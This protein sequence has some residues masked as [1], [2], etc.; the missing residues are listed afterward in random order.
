MSDSLRIC[1][2]SD[3][4]PGLHNSWG[5]AE[6]A[7][8]RVVQALAQRG[9]DISAITTRPD[10]KNVTINGISDLFFVST[11]ETATGIGAFRSLKQLTFPFD[12]VSYIEVRKVLRKTRPDVVHLHRINMISLSAALCAR[13]MGI[14]VVAS[15]YD[16]YY[17]CPRE[18]AVDGDGAACTTYHSRVCVECMDIRGPGF[19]KR[20]FLAARRACF[21]NLLKG[22]NFHVLSQSS[23]NILKTYGI[24]EGRIEKILQ[25]FPMTRDDEPSRTRKG[26]ITYI[27]WIQE[28]KGFHILLEAMPEIIRTCPEAR[29]TA[30]GAYNNDAYFDRVRNLIDQKG[31]AGRVEMLGKRDHA[32]VT[33]YVKESNVVVIPEQWDNMSP[34]VLVEAMSHGKPVVAS[35]IGGIPEFVEDG[36]SGLLAEPS[37]SEDFA[38]KISKVLA[39]EAFS[40]EISRS[41]KNHIRKI[42]DEKVI[43]K[44]YMNMYRKI[45]HA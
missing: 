25:V 26:L 4:L 1:H 23:L 20:S 39:D 40:E 41:A 14:P 11:V 31:L 36:K 8:L 37:S 18:T 17:F 3:T 38:G 33:R 10:L 24:D 12:P 28:R 29:L 45:A 34:V 13:K 43:I 9:V 42:L 35:N 21:D 5:G 2:V 6:Q 30:I 7:C 19:L 27:G 16:Y 22:V 44:D 15:I 32:E